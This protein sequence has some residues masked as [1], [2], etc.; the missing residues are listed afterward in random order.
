MCFCSTKTLCL[1]QDF[2]RGKVD[3]PLGQGGRMRPKTEDHEKL[4]EGVRV[5]L[6]ALEKRLLVRR[7]QEEG[8]RTLS[9]CCRAKL[10]KP[11]EQRRIVASDE[12]KAISQSMD[13]ELNRIGVNL[14]Q[15]ARNTNANKL[16]KLSEQDQHLLSELNKALKQ[17]YQMLEHYQKLLPK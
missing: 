5:R 12:F 16:Y 2:S 15:I 3:C 6:T 10:V 17:C 7:C 11:R 13:R 8:Y 1:Q 4:G 14:N 9:D